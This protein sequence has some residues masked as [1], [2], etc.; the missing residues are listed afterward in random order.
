MIDE[1]VVALAEAV[2]RA[3]LARGVRIATAESCTGGLIAGAI[4]A[5]AGS[6]DWFECGFVTYSNAA[7]RRE[8]GVARETIERFGAVSVE[9]AQAM[10]DGACRV[11][12]AECAVA[13]TGIAG[14]AGGTP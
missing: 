14:P 3:A 7:K 1:P 12:G 4:S 5:V 6:S 10:A 2:G 8:L 13:V 11:S 9:V